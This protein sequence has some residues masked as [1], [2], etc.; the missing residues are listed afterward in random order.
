MTPRLAR[1]RNSATSGQ[2][3][4]FTA[5]TVTAGASVPSTVHSGNP[6]VSTAN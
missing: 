1:T 4:T 5:A 3:T 6:T 2:L